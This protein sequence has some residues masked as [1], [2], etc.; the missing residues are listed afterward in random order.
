[1]PRVPRRT[2]AGT[3]SF[4]ANVPGDPSVSAAGLVPAG[5]GLRHYQVWYR[6]AADFCTSAT[7]NLSNGLSITWGA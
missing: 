1:V 6:N 7:F 5:G 2:T 4:G 3:A